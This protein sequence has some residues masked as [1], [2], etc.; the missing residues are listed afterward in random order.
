MIRNQSIWIVESPVAN[1]WVICNN[2]HYK[3]KLFPTL[4]LLLFGIVFQFLVSWESVKSYGY[5]SQPS[6]LLDTHP[7]QEIRSW[8]RIRY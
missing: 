1:F 4:L 6:Y 7:D 2:K 8:Q 5:P 3:A